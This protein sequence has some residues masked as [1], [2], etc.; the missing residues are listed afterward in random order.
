MAFQCFGPAGHPGKPTRFIPKEKERIRLGRHAVFVFLSGFPDQIREYSSAAK[1]KVS[2]ATGLPHAD[3]T[4]FAVS[5]KNWEGAHPKQNWG[6][7]PVYRGRRKVWLRFLVK[8]E[9]RSWVFAREGLQMAQKFALGCAGAISFQYGISP[10]VLRGF[11][12]FSRSVFSWGRR[13]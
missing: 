2:R 11:I 7:R 12:V 3:D 10:R 8:E 1:R 6:P 4:L 9:R 13:D 5:P